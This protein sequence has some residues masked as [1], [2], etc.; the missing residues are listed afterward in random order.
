MSV[1]VLPQLNST[2]QCASHGWMPHIAATGYNYMRCHADG[3]PAFNKKYNTQQSNWVKRLPSCSTLTIKCRYHRLQQDHK[4]ACVTDVPR[5]RTEPLLQR[6]KTVQ[7]RDIP[8][9]RS[10]DGSLLWFTHR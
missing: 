9:G 8:Y 10:A 5:F 3:W 2:L 6:C 4:Q 1:R 7:L